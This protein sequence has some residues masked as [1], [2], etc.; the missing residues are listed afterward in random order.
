MAVKLLKRVLVSVFLGANVMSVMLLWI[1]CAITWIDPSVCPRLAVA[2]LFFP[3]LLFVCLLFVPFWLLFKWRYVAV[4]VVGVLPCVGFALDYCPLNFRQGGGAEA[5]AELTV[6]SWNMMNFGYKGVSERQDEVLAYIDSVNAD[7][8]CLQE[9][10]GGPGVWALKQH[11][12]ERGYNWASQNGRTFYS[13]YPIVSEDVLQARSS[14]SNGINVYRLLLGADTLAVLNVHLESNYLTQEDRYDGRMA[15]KS[16]SSEELKQEGE[17]IWGKLALSQRCRG[18]QVDTLTRAIE[19]HFETGSVIVC[20]DF[21]DTP[22]SY[23]YQK[24]KRCNL[25]SAYREKGRGVGVSYNERF[26]FF[27]IDHLFH[28]GDWETLSARIDNS[29]LLSDHYPLIVKLGKHH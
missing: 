22:V 9:C 5:P 6:M 24:L 25:L 17:H 10:A 16:R 11:M 3:I 20:G 27:R 19:E 4:P 12:T 18:A 14:L 21:N 29:V 8:V 23:A 26:F 7:I 2:C 1:C 13:R 15:L 28:S